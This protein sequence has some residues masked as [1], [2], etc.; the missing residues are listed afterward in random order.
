MKNMSGQ[1]IDIE[2][3]KAEYNNPSSKLKDIIEF[4][5]EAG[6]SFKGAKKES[7][8]TDIE[9]SKKNVKKSAVRAAEKQLKKD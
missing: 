7:P 3:L 8:E 9:T 2:E 5:T 4:P 1:G 6:I